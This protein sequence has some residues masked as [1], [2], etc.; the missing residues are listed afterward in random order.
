VR[1]QSCQ[2]QAYL[3]GAW[4]FHSPFERSREEASY[5]KV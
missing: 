4:F 5:Q 3:E 1:F 2:G